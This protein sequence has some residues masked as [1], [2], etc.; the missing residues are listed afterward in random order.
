MAY[1]E[2]KPRYEVL[3]GL[4]GVAAF[5]VVMIHMME[6]YSANIVDNVMAHGFMAVDFFFALS[7]FVI[8]YAYDDRWGRMTMGDFFKRRIVRLQPLAALG[9]VLGMIFFYYTGGVDVYPRVN[10]TEWWQ[11]LGVGV[12]TFFMI[13]LPPSIEI[14]GWG[15]MCGLNGPMWTLIYEYIG[16]ILYAIFFRFLPTWGLAIFTALAGY[17]VIDHTLNINITGLI[18]TDWALYSV[19]GG[20]LLTPEHVWIAFARLLYPFCIGLLLARVGKKIHSNHGFLIASLMVL[21]IMAMPKLGGAPIAEGIYQSI[22]VLLLFPLILMIGAGSN[23][24]SK[25]GTRFCKLLGELSFPLYVTHY[26]INFLHVSWV[27][28]NMDAPMGTHIIVGILTFLLMIM[29]AYAALKAYDLPVRSWLKE[30][31]L[32]HSTRSITSSNT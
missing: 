18:H 14:R 6:C 5:C 2:S 19:V 26:P 12:L 23:L 9:V 8:G 30:H 4:R 32:K 11:L 27:Q 7:G 3:D 31:W 15:E 24:N 16:N 28:R 17:M 20:Y 25:R 1:L 29:V 21:V 13:G 10:D 22:C